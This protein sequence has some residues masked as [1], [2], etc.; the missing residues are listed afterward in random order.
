MRRPRPEIEIFDPL[1]PLSP[2]PTRAARPL[3]AGQLGELMSL[4]AAFVAENSNIPA[5]VL[6]PLSLP[7]T[8]RSATPTTEPSPVPVVV[9]EEEE[10]DG[11]EVSVAP[12]TGP[13]RVSE[14]LPPEVPQ[15]PDIPAAGGTCEGCDDFACILSNEDP[16]SVNA[17]AWFKAHRFF[18]PVCLEHGGRHIN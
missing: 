2:S 14:S 9:V 18:L 17:E 8:P 1:D 10:E 5:N 11:I 4:F 12:A 16:L 3:D 6:L 15:V 7:R 13:P